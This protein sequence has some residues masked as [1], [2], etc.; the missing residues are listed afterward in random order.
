MRKTS[1]LILAILLVG[2]GS[3]LAGGEGDTADREAT[4]VYLVR[5]AEKM[6][7]G[8]SK[9]PKNPDLTEAG[10]QRADLLARVLAD[11]GVERIYST[12]Y[13]RTMATASPLARKLGVEVERYDP[14]DLA[15]FAK[16]LRERGGRV[17]ISGHSNT[18]PALVEALGGEPGSP[19]DEASEYDRLYVLVIGPA[20]T[21]TMLLR[22]G[23]PSGSLSVPNRL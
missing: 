12:D 5:H 3:A 1:T 21:T 7:A 18:T 17:L 10:K 23:S 13:V 20:D 8:A 16:R 4:V 2:A 6:D 22:Y 9:D 14:T 15:G 19:I 11:A